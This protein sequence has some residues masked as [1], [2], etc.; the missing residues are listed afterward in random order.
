MGSPF[1]RFCPLIRALNENDDSIVL[2]QR[3]RYLSGDIADILQGNEQ[4][5]R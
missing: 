5:L 3:L 4:V 1:Q 2:D